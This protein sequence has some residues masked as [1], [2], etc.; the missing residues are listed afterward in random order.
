MDRL[1]R[2]PNGGA[3]RPKAED[4]PLEQRIFESVR[5]TRAC[6]KLAEQLSSSFEPKIA[7]EI[8]AWSAR[9][10]QQE[11]TNNEDFAGSLADLRRFP[12]GAG[13]RAA[14]T[15]S[16]T[17]GQLTNWSMNCSISSMSWRLLQ[18]DGVG[19]SHGGT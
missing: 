2:F 15:I 9:F 12:Q 4:T 16:M 14:T 18:V 19:A 10:R 13:W 3:R 11:F 5:L 17:T 6:G 7:G 1:R 8:A